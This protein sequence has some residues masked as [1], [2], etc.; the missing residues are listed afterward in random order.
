MNY[1][2]YS[3]PTIP[4]VVQFCREIVWELNGLFVSVN[5]INSTKQNSIKA[6]WKFVTRQRQEWA[7]RHTHSSPLFYPGLFQASTEQR[8]S[9]YITLAIIIPTRS[10]STTHRERI[11]I[12][13]QI[14]IYY[15]TMTSFM[16]VYVIRYLL[17]SRRGPFFNC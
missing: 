10:K 3:T 11:Q 15:V 5:R 4:L 14:N 13:L 1:L 12:Q 7:R 16:S 6:G 2:K 9:L 17:F 8:D